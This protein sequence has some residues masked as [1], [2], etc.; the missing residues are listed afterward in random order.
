MAEADSKGRK[1]LVQPL[2][3]RNG[4]RPFGQDH[5]GQLGLVKRA[6]LGQTQQTSN[7]IA[8]VQHLSLRMLSWRMLSWQMASLVSTRGRTWLPWFLGESLIGRQRFLPVIARTAP[9]GLRYWSSKTGCIPLVQNQSEP[10]SHS[11]RRYST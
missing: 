9:F 3:T 8:A 6:R 5:F 11:L 10:A 2:A 7:H 1:S 4:F